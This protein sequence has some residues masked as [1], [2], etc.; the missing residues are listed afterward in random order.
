M[1][2]EFGWAKHALRFITQHKLRGTVTWRST[3]ERTK[4]R[5][6]A[7][8][9]LLAVKDVYNKSIAGVRMFVA[10]GVKDSSNSSNASKCIEMLQLLL[11]KRQSQSFCQPPVRSGVTL[12]CRRFSHAALLPHPLI[13][14]RDHTQDLCPVTWRRNHDACESQIVI[15]STL[16]PKTIAK[17]K[18]WT[19]LLVRS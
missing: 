9:L 16:W 14:F 12:V 2:E 5:R 8:P 3:N 7:R 19:L 13:E 17:R 4:N 1:Y 11:C 18:R 6:A 15:V 10:R